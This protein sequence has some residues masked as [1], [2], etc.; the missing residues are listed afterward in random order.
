MV[1]WMSPLR[2]LWGN[3]SKKFFRNPLELLKESYSSINLWITF[4]YF[5]FFGISFSSFF[6]DDFWEFI[7]QP[8]QQ[9]LGQFFRKLIWGNHKQ[10]IIS[11]G[12]SLRNS[13]SIFEYLFD[14]SIGFCFFNSFE[15]RFRNSGKFP[16]W[17]CFG[18][19]LQQFFCEMFRQVLW[20]FQCLSSSRKPLLLLLL[21]NNQVY[22]RIL[23]QS[24]CEKYEFFKPLRSCCGSF[25]HGIFQDF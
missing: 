15:N 4:P 9:L 22:I 21:E 18:Q 7:W 19:H 24:D 13:I 2:S 1:L 3:L 6:G 25:L 23:N 11:F 20:K 17:I 10:F 8:I 5:N 14:N 12:S 16:S